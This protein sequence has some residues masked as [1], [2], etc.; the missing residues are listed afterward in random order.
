[1][2]AATDAESR[3]RDDCSHCSHC[4]Q[5]GLARGGRRGVAESQIDAT[6]F[7]LVAIL[8]FIWPSP[9]RRATGNR[10]TRPHTQDRHRH[11]CA[12]LFF[13]LNHESDTPSTAIFYYSQSAVPFFCITFTWQATKVMLP[14]KFISMK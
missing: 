9:A 6:F 2:T 11:R 14:L 4:S 1:M 3:A 10:R 5:D 8:V 13:D 7:P 12:S